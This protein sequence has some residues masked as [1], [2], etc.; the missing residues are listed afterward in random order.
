VLVALAWPSLGALPWLVQPA[1]V[2]AAAHDHP[3]GSQPHHHVDPSTI[4]GSP[5]HPDHHDCFECQVLQHLARCV[6]PAPAVAIVPSI[7][8]CDAAPRLPVALPRTHVTTVFPLAR[9]PPTTTL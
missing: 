8:A 1:H 7:V 4:P 9:A 6:F 3:H 5:S 2:L